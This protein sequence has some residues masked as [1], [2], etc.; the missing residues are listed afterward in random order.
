MTGFVDD[1]RDFLTEYKVTGI[2]IAFIIGSATTSFVT[3]F[4]NDVIMP[5]ISPL[6]KGGNW[7]TAVAKIGPFNI[8]WG[9]FLAAALNFAL[10]V[11]VV[12]AM[13][14][15]IRRADMI[16]SKSKRHKN[17]VK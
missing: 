7:Q 11:L 9:P 10:I 12:F 6:T 16:A 2:A 17:H 5:L 1:F 15:L 14:K 8:G 13:V 4:V 3:S